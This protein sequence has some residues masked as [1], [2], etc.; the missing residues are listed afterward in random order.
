MGTALDIWNDMLGLLVKKIVPQKLWRSRRFSKFMAAFSQPLV[1]LTDKVT[2]QIA[3]Q[4][5]C[6]KT[7]AVRIDVTIEDP[8]EQSSS[9]TKMVSFVQAH[10][11]FR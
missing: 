7:H 9:R 3:P 4:G 5:N 10:A 8:S 11:S 6:G 1:L 2:Q